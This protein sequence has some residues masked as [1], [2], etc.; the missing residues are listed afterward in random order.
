MCIDTISRN[1]IANTAMVHCNIINPSRPAVGGATI[2]RA[3]AD[4][5]AQR[6]GSESCFLRVGRGILPA[7]RPANG[8]RKIKGIR[9]A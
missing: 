4:R 2:K 6:I 7:A 8:R 9:N 3:F 1:G 5:F